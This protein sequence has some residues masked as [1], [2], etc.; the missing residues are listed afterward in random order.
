MMISDFHSHILPGMD[1]GSRNVE[2]SIA[3]LELDAAQGV[4]QVVLTPHFYPHN[5]SPERFLRRRDKAEAE[6]RRAIEGRED[7]PLLTVGAEVAYY[8]GMSQ[9]EALPDLTLRGTDCI[10]IEMPPS[11]WPKSV[12]RELRAIREDRGLQ[13]IIAHVD[14]YIRPFRTHGIPKRLEEEGLLVQANANFFLYRDTQ[15]MALKMLK[16]GRIHVI[17]SDCHN[18]ETRRPNLQNAVEKIQQKL[19]RDVLSRISDYERRIIPEIFR[20]E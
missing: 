16:Q 6:L 15:R 2:E 13:P 17:G 10:L 5:E 8:L 9:S 19:G 4:R 14:R 18:L 1:D 7:L 11:P 3:L 20:T 12:W